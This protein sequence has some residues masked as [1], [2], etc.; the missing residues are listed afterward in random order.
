MSEEEEEEDSCMIETP[1]TFSKHLWN[2]G[3]PSLGTMIVLCDELSDELEYE[4]LSVDWTMAIERHSCITM[5]F[6]AM[7]YIEA[8]FSNQMEVDFFK[9]MCTATQQNMN[10]L[11]QENT[12]VMEGALLRH[13]L[14]LLKTRKN[15]SLKKVIR[16]VFIKVNPVQMTH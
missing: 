1:T 13:L 2:I 6:Y 14:L 5:E 11:Q 3:G 12:S 15:S 9:E 10:E 16:S 7:L 4:K 8:A